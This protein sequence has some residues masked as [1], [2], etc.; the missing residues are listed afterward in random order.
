MEFKL[1][2]YI[3]YFTNSVVYVSNLVIRLIRDILWVRPCLHWTKAETVSTMIN[4]KVLTL[5]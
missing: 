5:M 2:Q 1:T 4:L 3:I